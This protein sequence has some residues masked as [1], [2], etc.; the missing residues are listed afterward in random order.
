MERKKL[1]SAGSNYTHLRGLFAVPG[2]ALLILAALGNWEWG[3][4]SQDWLFLVALLAVMT[5]SL[6]IARYYNEQYGRITIST[7]QR[8]RA[9]I[10]AVGTTA[11]ML[12]VSFLLRSDA[13]W[14]LDLPVNGLAA[15][16]AVGFLSYYA[17]TV[18]VKPHHAIIWGPLLVGA[19]LPVWG[20]LDLTDTSNLGLVLAGV[21]AIAS[22]I[23][24]HRF[25][26]RSLEPAHDLT[27]TAG[28]VRA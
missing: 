1:Q 11:L 9:A 20:G 28:D 2:G 5:A 22:G 6:G 13:D 12:A 17:V 23:F 7:E 25:L 18:G 16:L 3:P 14:S 4:L 10:A 27:P 8:A 19:L 15:A 24:D 26:V 21:A